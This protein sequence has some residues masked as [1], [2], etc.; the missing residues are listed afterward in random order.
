M[1]E[2]RVW[3]NGTVQEASSDPYP[4]MSD[5]YEYVWADDEEQALLVAN[6]TKPY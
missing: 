3:P 1:I 4:F 5:D 2:Y 6:S